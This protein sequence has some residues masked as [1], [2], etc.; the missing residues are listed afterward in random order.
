[1]DTGYR[2]Q[3]M[4]VRMIV[5]IARYRTFNF[6]Q[7]FGLSHV[8]SHQCDVLWHCKYPSKKSIDQLILCVDEHKKVEG[9]GS[10]QYQHRIEASKPEIGKEY[11]GK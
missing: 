10:K 8:V 11:T 4:I 9:E 3:W 6:S 2:I 7:D 5:R 1:M